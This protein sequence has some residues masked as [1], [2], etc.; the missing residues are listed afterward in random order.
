MSHGTSGE[1]RG[2]LSDISSPLS[3]CGSQGSNSDPQTWQPV[4]LP[5]QLSHQPR[6]LCLKQHPVYFRVPKFGDLP[7]WVGVMRCI[8]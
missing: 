1:V 4:P 5:A 8:R 6:I 2:Q 7:A 3:L